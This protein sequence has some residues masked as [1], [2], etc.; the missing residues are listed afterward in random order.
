MKETASDGTADC[1][2]KKTKMDMEETKVLSCMSDYKIEKTLGVSDDGRVVFTLGSISGREGKAIV[3]FETNS[4]DLERVKSFL[5]RESTLKVTMQNDIYSVLRLDPPPNTN[6][7]KTTVMFPATEKLI[8]KFTQKPAYLVTET[9]DLYMKITRP[10]ILDHLK[11]HAWVYNI[12]EGRAEQDRVLCSE[13]GEDKGFVL[14]ADLKWDMTTKA[15]LYCLAIVQR[16]DLHSVRDLTAEHVPLLRDLRDT[17][18]GAL[19]KRFGVPSSL[20]R[21]YLHYQ[22]AYYHL[23]VHFAHLRYM[24]GAPVIGKSLAL[25]DVIQ[26]LEICGEYYSRATLQYYIKD[27]HALSKELDKQGAIVRD[28]QDVV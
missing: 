4:L 9:P 19:Q 20:I 24:A 10:Y 26:N 28:D 8:N 25:N 21:V 14:A 6:T 7:I 11:D 23:H 3:L 17:C 13:P 12:L 27:G 15:N 22:P 16:R 2:A 18:L 1:P 5:S